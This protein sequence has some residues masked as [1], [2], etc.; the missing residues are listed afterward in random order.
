M[1][2]ELASMRASHKQKWASGYS[3]GKVADMGISL[4]EKRRK[5]NL[6]VS[7]K[8]CN[9]NNNNIMLIGLFLKIYSIVVGHAVFSRHKN[10]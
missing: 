1:Y 2:I 8:S 5:E 6:Y 7:L 4:T 10:Y 3:E 9:K